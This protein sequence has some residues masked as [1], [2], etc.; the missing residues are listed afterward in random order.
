MGGALAACLLLTVPASAATPTPGSAGIG[1]PYLPDSGNGG[2]DVSHYDL[3]LQYR[4]RT[5]RL[6]GTATLLATATQD[7]S[8][9]DLDFVLDVQEVLVDGKRAAFA[10]AGAH[11]LQVTPRTPLS[12]GRPFTVV[13]RY[14]DVPSEK[15]VDGHS[16]WSRTPDGAVVAGE[17]AAAAWWFPSNDHPRDKATYDISV[18]VPEGLQ[19]VSNGILS[20]RSTQRGWTRYTWRST[21]P[22]ATYLATLAVGKFEIAQGTTSNGLPVI[23]AYSKDLGDGLAP[24]KASIERTGEVID[25][26]STLFGPYPF[27]A[28]GGY[29]P[30]LPGRGA[31]ETQTRPVY[32]SGTFQNGAFM[33]VVVHELA[34]QWFGDSV[35]VRNWR[36]TWLSEGF[37]TYA[38]WLWSEKEGEGTARE[39]ADYAYASQPADDPFWKVRPA[40]PGKDNPLHNAVY[41]RGA[42][43]LQALRE[44]IGDSTFFTVLKEWQKQRRHGNATVEDFTRLA[45]DVSG[46]SLRRLFDTWLYTPGKPA[47]GPGAAGGKNGIAQ[48]AQPVQPKSWKNLERARLSHRHRPEL[49]GADRS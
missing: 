9:F 8:R 2:Y 42:M 3:R 29:V 14:G 12:K 26:A 40:D 27:E 30:N 19:T 32:A 20:S 37:A 48:A 10:K 7:L 43:A 23:N 46:K 36:D 13:V 15:K 31:L 22:Q 16:A 17:P 49:T 24:A 38:E 39:L 28:A 44:K 4:P 35:S 47:Q 18:A 11:E 5:D 1:D 21:K 45:Q 6:D 41:L 25:W 33:E 34:H